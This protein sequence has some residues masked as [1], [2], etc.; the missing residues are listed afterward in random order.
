VAFFQF[1]QKKDFATRSIQGITKEKFLG[2]LCGHYFNF[3]LT[4]TLQE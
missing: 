1:L 2:I 4:Y 3:N